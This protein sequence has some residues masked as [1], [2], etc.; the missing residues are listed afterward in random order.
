MRHP[1]A[2]GSSEVAQFLT[3]LAVEKNVA[4]STQNHALSNPIP[5]A[6]GRES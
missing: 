6:M 3:H 5:R 4:A 1:E 2:M